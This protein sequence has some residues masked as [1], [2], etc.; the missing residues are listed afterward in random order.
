M[1]EPIFDDSTPSDVLFPAGMGRGL[2]PRDY[3]VD[4]PEMFAPPSE[5]ALIPRSEWSARIKEQEQLKSRTSDVLLAAEIPSLNQGPI[6]YCATADTE[7]LTPRGWVGYPDYNWTDPVATVSPV[8]HRME[9]QVP[10]QRHVYDYDGPMIYSTHQRLDFGVTPDHQMY[11]RKW[12]EAART[13]SPNYSFVRAADLGW[14]AGFLAAPSGWL[15]T[16]LVEVEVPG[17]RRYDGDDFLA[18]VGI[19]LSCGCAGGTE[20]TRNW[21]SFCSFREA[22]RGRVEALAHRI[23]FR[24]SPSRRGVFIRYNAGALAEWF[25]QNAYSGGSRSPNKRV[26][27]IVKVA[28]VRQIK[29]FMDWFND[30]DR[31]GRYFYSSSR[32][33]I[34]DLQELH[35]RVGRRGSISYAEGRESRFGDKVIRSSGQWTLSVS[36]GEQLSIERKRQIETDRYR[37]PVYCAGVPNHTLI[38]RR[39][40]SVLVSSNCWSHSTVGCVQAVRAV[41]NQPYVPLSA[42]AVAATIKA[43]RDEG[44]W[45][46]LSAKFLR[47]RGV[48]SQQLWPQGDRAY[49]RYDTPEVWANAAL[50]KVTEDWT[51]LTREVY[52]QNLTFDQLATCLLVGVPCAVDFNWWGHSVMACDLVEV[53]PG[54]FGVRIRNSWG[55]AWGEKGFGILRGQKAIPDGALA[56]RVAGA[57]PA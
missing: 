53:E 38:T 14:Y 21:V 25:R 23:G 18:M 42:Y 33:L 52:D 44:G 5:L 6:G 32:R 28:S 45:C 47:E 43:G 40:G 3:A 37:G 49:R 1:P 27:D 24:E 8:T 29:L 30:R 39:N 7:V 9:F 11:V 36:A 19:V 4:P 57:S 22:D 51:D 50:H 17:D 26:P 34:D 31:N 16:E 12:D 46:G 13:L 20:K 15:G 55:D 35:L 56:I 41:N 48:P 2:V 10:F 54:S